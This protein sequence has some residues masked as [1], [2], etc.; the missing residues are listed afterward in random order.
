MNFRRICFYGG[1]GTGK[2]TLAARIFAELKSLHYDVEYVSEFVKTMAYEGKIP[3]SY[4]QIHI[5]G[6][7]LHR[8]DLLLK[9]VQLIITDSPIILGGVYAKFYNAPGSDEILKI[10]EKFE[11]DF[12][13]LNFYV[14]RKVDYLSKGRFQNL[15]EAV[16]F[17]KLLQDMMKIHLK[18]FEKIEPQFPEMAL[19]KILI[20]TKTKN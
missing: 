6:E 13:S 2:S 15:S 17:D 5:F 12:P 10:A 14:E 9:H 19:Q 16:A 4:D 20:E 7:Q 1:A 3:C 11:E 18:S 8:E